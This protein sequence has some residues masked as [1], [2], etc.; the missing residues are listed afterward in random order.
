MVH[1]GLLLRFN[2][3]HQTIFFKILFVEFAN[4][5]TNINC[6][7]REKSSNTHQYLTSTKCNT[8]KGKKINIKGVTIHNYL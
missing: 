8:V 1:Y 4:N 7:I 6:L 2:Y 5:N 3:Q